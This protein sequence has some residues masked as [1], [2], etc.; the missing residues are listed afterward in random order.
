MYQIRNQ[1]FLFSKKTNKLNSTLSGAY[2]HPQSSLVHLGIGYNMS[3]HA[4]LSKSKCTK[5][6]RTKSPSR[7]MAQLEYFCNFCIL[8]PTYFSCS[9]NHPRR[10]TCSILRKSFNW[11]GIVLKKGELSENLDISRQKVLVLEL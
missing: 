8:H 1:I 2:P 5:I 3:F 4:V 7:E 9:N 10:F 6:G 11:L